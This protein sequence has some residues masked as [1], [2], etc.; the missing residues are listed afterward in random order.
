MELGYKLNVFEIFMLHSAP[1]GNSFGRI[2]AKHALGYK[3]YTYT[4]QSAPKKFNGNCRHV[5]KY[6]SI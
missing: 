1:G 5:K 6:F 4:I 2:Q 3:R